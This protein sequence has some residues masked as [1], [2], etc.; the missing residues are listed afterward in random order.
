MN[1]DGYIRYVPRTQ[2]QKITQII[3]PP[4]C[5][6]IEKYETYNA[7]FIFFY[8]RRKKWVGQ[9]C[10]R[11]GEKKLDGYIRRRSGGRGMGRHTTYKSV[12]GYIRHRSRGREVRR[13]RM[14]IE[15]EFTDLLQWYRWCWRLTWTEMSTRWRSWRQLSRPRLVLQHT[16]AHPHTHIHTAVIILKR[17]QHKLELSSAAV[18]YLQLSRRSLLQSG[19]KLTQQWWLITCTV[20]KRLFDFM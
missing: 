14:R 12:D 4:I 10:Y 3:P 15:D 9:I 11:H 20:F 5:R 13:C 17:S 2:E 18:Y 16:H 8:I 6:P 19:V 1:R 7:Y